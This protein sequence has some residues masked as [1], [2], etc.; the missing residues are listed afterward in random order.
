MLKSLLL[1]FFMSASPQTLNPAAHGV[2]DSY[3]DLST[4]MECSDNGYLLKFGEPYCRAFVEA[5]PS[6]TPQGKTFL[7]QIRACLLDQLL[8]TS[9][10]VTCH[11]VQR[12]SEAAHVSCYVQLGFCELAEADKMRI[13]SVVWP[14]LFQPSFRGVIR[15]IQN[16]CV[17]LTS[18]K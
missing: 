9:E 11:N 1:F 4:K 2:C 17:V 5:E 13:L 8:N 12:I 6:F 16:Q 10:Q 18:P 15:Q 3:R 7:R 14:E